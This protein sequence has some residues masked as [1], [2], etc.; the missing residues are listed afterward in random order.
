MCH[1]NKLILLN[2]VDDESSS[3]FNFNSLI[4]KRVIRTV[5]L[6]RVHFF[7]SHRKD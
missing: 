6:I 3:Y 2:H 7:V 4:L 1:V 5:G